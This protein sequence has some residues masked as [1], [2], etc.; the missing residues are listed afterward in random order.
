MTDNSA[1]QSAASGAQWRQRGQAAMEALGETWGGTAEVCRELSTTEWG[2]PTECPGWDVKDQLSHLIGI[3]L[4]IMG[5]PAPQWDRPLGD[6]VKND[7]AAAN[8]P[9]IA[10]R[11][12]NSGPEVLAEFVDVTRRR[13]AQEADKTEDEWAAVGWSPVGQRPHAVFMEVRVFDSWVHEQDVRHALDRPGGTGTRASAISLG[14]VEDAMPFVVGKKA[15]CPDGTV[16]RFDVAGDGADARVVT[17][18]VEGGR[19]RALSGAQADAATPTATLSLSAV[20]FMRLGC[21]RTTAPAIE[22]A[23][24][25]TVSGDDGVGRQVL[26]AMNFMF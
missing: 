7:V 11:R 13:L 20:D 17:V 24:G 5:E 9:W 3:E 18:E 21:G 16:V 10:V 26:A 23:G 8:E 25:L 12:A 19:A 1:G 4:A 15:A 14:R 2:L 22:A 6:H